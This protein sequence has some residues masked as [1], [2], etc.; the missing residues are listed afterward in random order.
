MSE[1][2]SASNTK[3]NLMGLE[4]TLDEIVNKKQPLQL[5]A[6][7]RKWLAENVWWLSLIGGI[8]TLYGAFS[9]W[10]LSQ[11]AN[12]YLEVAR[13]YGGSAVTDLGAMW[14]VALA[15]MVAEG[16]MLLLAVSKLK[17]QSKSGWNLLFYTTLLSL[18]LGVVYLLVPQ[19]GVSSLFGT[20]VGTAIGWFFLFQ[21]RSHFVKA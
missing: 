20:L 17:T 18:V 16:V 8:L 4:K 6:N 13:M 12:P 1:K 7:A 2:T 15:V 21:V 10:R 11:V 5:P 14:Y 9:V 3:S 19:Y